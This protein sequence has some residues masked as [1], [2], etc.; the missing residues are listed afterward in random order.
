MP[1]VRQLFTEQDFQEAI[2]KKL[3]IRVFH[4]DHLIDSGSVM[5]RFTEETVITQS[6]VSE[7]AYHPR[8]ECQFF[9]VR[10]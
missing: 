9:E 2:D 6:N 8:K 4:N 5:I 10:K 7:L 1:T 3:R